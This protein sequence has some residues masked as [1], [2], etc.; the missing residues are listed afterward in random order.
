MLTPGQKCKE[1]DMCHSLCRDWLQDT[2]FPQTAWNARFSFVNV[3][4]VS[5][6]QLKFKSQS[7]NWKLYMKS[8]TFIVNSYAE[9]L[10]KV[11]KYKNVFYSMIV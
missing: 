6:K 9:F 11:V 10:S 4:V 7:I 1:L 3:S 8:E 2:D 5:L